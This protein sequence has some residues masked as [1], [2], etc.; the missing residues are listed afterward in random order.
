MMGPQGY[1]KVKVDHDEGLQYL[2]GFMLWHYSI[3][4]SH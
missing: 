2:F 3:F 1:C 4:K